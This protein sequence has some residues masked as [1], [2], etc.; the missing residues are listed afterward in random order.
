M[1]NFFFFNNSINSLVYVPLFLPLFSKWL[2]PSSVPGDHTH[3]ICS[4]TYQAYWDINRSQILRYIKKAESID[5]VNLIAY[6]QKLL[7]PS[8]RTF[9]AITF[10]RNHPT[11]Y[12][13]ITLRIIPVSAISLSTLLCL[14]CYELSAPIPNNQ[15]RRQWS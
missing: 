4:L 13:S 3:S 8:Y 12:E 10:S 5:T 14:C 2:D 7:S 6:Q 15:Y 11:K 1:N 9:E